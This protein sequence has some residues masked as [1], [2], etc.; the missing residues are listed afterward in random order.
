[1][2]SQLEG[3]MA[4]FESS[5]SDNAHVLEQFFGM[6]TLTASQVAALERA[7]EAGEDAEAAGG[8]TA[9]VIAAI[10][11]ELVSENFEAAQAVRDALTAQVSSTPSDVVAAV[12][13]VIDDVV[14][15]ALAAT[16]MD[17]SLF[18]PVAVEEIREGT[19]RTEVIEDRDAALV[20]IDQARQ[21]A[22]AGGATSE[23]ADEV[24]DQKREEELQ[25]TTIVD[26]DPAPSAPTDPAPEAIVVLSNADDVVVST[27][28][29]DDRFEVVPQVFVDQ[30]DNALTSQ[31]AGKDVIVDLDSRDSS[32]A[33]SGAGGHEVDL[34]A[35]GDVVYLEG[36]NGIGDVNFERQQIGREGQNSLKITTTVKGVDA[37][38]VEVA[39]NTSEVNIFKQF[40]A[41]TDR[42]AIET[43]EISNTQGDSEYWSLSTAEAV[44]GDGRITDTY[45]T[46]DVSN[47]GKGILIGSDTADDKYVVNADADDSA[48]IMVVGFDATDSI[49]LT[50]FG[51]DLS[52]SL[53]GSDVEVSNANGDIVVTLIGLGAQTDID[54]QLILMST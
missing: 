29:A 19:V 15:E 25:V 18:V 38:D 6:D 1:M 34:N 43:L 11:A 7:A 8:D 47:T 17:T 26:R 5:T 13:A 31:D 48:E 4:Q 32:G 23:E 52:A 27:S 24:A 53:N 21:D 40:D 3:I 30:A 20:A 39:S 37:N 16:D 44:R 28:G 10:D 51:A 50:D 2:K 42:F 46:T 14:D 54:N 45:I 49:D 35:L 36:V 12:E 33:G 9:A 41:L 22:L